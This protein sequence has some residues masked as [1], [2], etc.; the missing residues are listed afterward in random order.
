MSSER[1]WTQHLRMLPGGDSDVTSAIIATG[2]LYVILGLI[3]LGIGE[4]V[5]RSISFDFGPMGSLSVANSL[6]CLVIAVWT[7]IR[8]RTTKHIGIDEAAVDLKRKRVFYGDEVARVPSAAVVFSVR[9]RQA[10]VSMADDRRVTLFFRVNSDPEDLITLGR[11]LRRHPGLATEDYVHQ[12]AEKVVADL[13][14][15]PD[16]VKDAMTNKLLSKGIVITRAEVV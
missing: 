4:A 14:P 15:D 1:S 6:P 8:V 13:L 2:L 10:T 9:P 7:G 12:V 5:V 16:G 3:G 11:T